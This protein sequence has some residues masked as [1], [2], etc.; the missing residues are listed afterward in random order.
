MNLTAVIALAV[1]VLILF[2]VI[3]AMA[4]MI[5]VL[6]RKST[7]HADNPV[8]GPD[9]NLPMNIINED[10]LEPR[11]IECVCQVFFQQIPGLL[12]NWKF[13]FTIFPK[14]HLSVRILLI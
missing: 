5:H 12:N 11:I 7:Y 1:V 4:V 2:M 6:R 3:V 14:E 9:N 10:R 13:I 8:G